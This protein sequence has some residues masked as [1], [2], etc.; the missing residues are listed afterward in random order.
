VIFRS[1]RLRRSQDLRLFRSPGKWDSDWFLADPAVTRFL[2]A[3]SSLA[4]CWKD[5]DIE[6][7]AYAISPL[8]NLVL[9][10]GGIRLS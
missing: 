3:T 4:G 9:L 7:A 5:V 2:G 1:H 8:M 10:W 6:Q